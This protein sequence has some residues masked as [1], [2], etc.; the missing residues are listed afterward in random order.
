VVCE[1]HAQIIIF[2]K[3]ITILKLGHIELMN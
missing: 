3:E 1:G 2:Q